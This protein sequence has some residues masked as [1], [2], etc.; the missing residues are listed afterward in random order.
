LARNRGY[1]RSDAPLDIKTSIDALAPDSPVLPVLLAADPA[2][3]VRYHNVVGHD[4]DPGWE[5]Y[6]IGEGD[7]VVSLASSR[8]DEMPRLRSQITVPA[9]HSGVHRHPQSVL[10]VRRVLFEQLAEL[11]DFPHSYGTQVAAQASRIR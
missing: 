6:L 8:L 2:P 3:W 5:R 1:F 9:D 11:Q 4:P 7:G 10:E